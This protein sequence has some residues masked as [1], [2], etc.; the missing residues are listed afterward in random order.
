MNDS[1]KLL[2]TFSTAAGVTISLNLVTKAQQ[3]SVKMASS[4]GAGQLESLWQSSSWWSRANLASTN[5][6]CSGSTIWHG[7]VKP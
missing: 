2:A 4:A 7:K 6:K 1:L 3:A 5:A